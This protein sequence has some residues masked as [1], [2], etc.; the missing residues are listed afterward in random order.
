M[1]FSKWLENTPNDE[2]NLK[3]WSDVWNAAVDATIQALLDGGN[4]DE[5]YRDEWT[6]TANKVKDSDE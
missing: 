3:T 5:Y 2:L 1:T 4:I 6:E